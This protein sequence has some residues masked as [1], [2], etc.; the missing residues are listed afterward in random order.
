VK[1]RIIF[2]SL[3]DGMELEELELDEELFESQDADD[4]ALQLGI[5]PSTGLSAGWAVSV[6]GQQKNDPEEPPSIGWS[7]AP[8]SDSELGLDDRTLQTSSRA[9]RK[10]IHASKSQETVDPKDQAGAISV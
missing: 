8:L 4:E 5:D 10:V 3:Q 9:L 6:L 1:R 7:M 2:M